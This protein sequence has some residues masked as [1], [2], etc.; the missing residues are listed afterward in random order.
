MF[1]VEDDADSRDAL[2]VVF[3][4]GS[5]LRTVASVREAL[6]AYD[7]QPPDLVISDVGMPGEN[8]YVPDSC[9]PD[10]EEGGSLEP[11]RSRSPDSPAARIMRRLPRWLRRA[12][13]EAVEPDDLLDRVRVLAA[14]RTEIGHRTS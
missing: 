1:L 2:N 14:S 13:C 11:W 12:R 9:D 4:Q 3:E 8:G 7:A 5:H 10:R 6:A